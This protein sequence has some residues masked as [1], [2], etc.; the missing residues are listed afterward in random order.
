MQNCNLVKHEGRCDGAEWTE[1]S[2]C[3][4]IDDEP[5]KSDRQMKIVLIQSLVDMNAQISKQSDAFEILFGS[6]FAGEGGVPRLIND[7]FCKNME[8]V[9]QLTGISKEAIEWFL[10]DNEC[11]QSNMA[12][13]CNGVEY[14]IG[15]VEQFVD[16]ETGVSCDD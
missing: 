9:T 7:L 4:A 12:A 10:F 11:G 5:C 14:H 3:G 15:S 16:F 2:Y 13:S 8:L 1:C 6:Y